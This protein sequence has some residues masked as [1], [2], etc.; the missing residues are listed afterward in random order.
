MI[1][2]II[3]SF[4]ILFFGIGLVYSLREE[5]LE[6]YEPKIIKR[7]TKAILNTGSILILSPIYLLIATFYL[8]IILAGLLIISMLLKM[9]SNF[10][11]FICLVIWLVTIQFYPKWFWK[12]INMQ[13]NCVST[14]IHLPK[15]AVLWLEYTF[16]GKIISYIFAVLFVLL[17][18]S[19]VIWG[20]D[21][22]KI[23]AGT[24]KEFVDILEASVLVFIAI[25][26]VIEIIKTKAKE[27]KKNE[28]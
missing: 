27:M 16:R 25:D 24:M 21:K 22:E 10:P 9:N 23:F 2:S 13:V 6:D 18:Q 26:I 3:C 20:I 11:I 12:F 14:L 5:N 15:K 8:L 17:D 19:N 28:I 7:F 4:V 1:S